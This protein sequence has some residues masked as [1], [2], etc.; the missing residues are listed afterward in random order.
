MDEIIQV[1]GLGYR[2]IGQYELAELKKNDAFLSNLGLLFCV[3]MYEEKGVNFSASHGFW[4]FAVKCCFSR[5]A[6]VKSG[7]Y[8][9][10][11]LFR[12]DERR[13]SRASDL[14]LVV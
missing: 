13:I 7:E 2:N 5:D 11:E 9:F 14:Y 4:N 8:Q 12:L 6:E 3:Y 10:D 1:L